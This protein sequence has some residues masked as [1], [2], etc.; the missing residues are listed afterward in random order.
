MEDRPDQ[1]VRDLCLH[2]LSLPPSERESFLNRNCGEGTALLSEVQSLLAYETAATDFL[3][4]PPLELA[5]RLL[6]QREMES[7]PLLDPELKT[8][9]SISHYEI[10]EKLGAGGM[11]LVY[12]ARDTELDR[13]VALKFLPDGGYED[14]HTLERFRREARAAAALNHPNVCTIHE[15]CRDGE[16]VFLVMEFLEGITLKEAIRGRSLGNEQILKLAIQVAE[17]LKAGHEAGIIHCDIKSAN[18]FLT[19][20]GAKIL[21]FGLAR[22]IEPGQT[23]D[24]DRL[25]RLPPQPSSRSTSG[26]SGTTRGAHGTVAYMSPEQVSGEPVDRRTDLFS[27]GVVLYEMTTGDLPFKGDSTAEIFDRILRHMPVPAT[28]L[29]P[30]FPA[31]LDGIID[32]ALTKDRMSRY[33]SAD[34]LLHDLVEFRNPTDRAAVV[35]TTTWPKWQTALLLLSTL[36]ILSAV[37]FFVYSRYRW[38]GLTNQDTIVLAE[39]ENK[40][41]DSIFDQTLQQAL[42]VQLEQSIF[43]NVL[44][45]EK[46]GEQLRF[47]A[48][49]ADTPVSREVAREICLRTGSQAVV[50]GSIS[51]LADD[52]V[53][54][55]N[56]VACQ[57][58]KSLASELTH[59]KNRDQVL[60]A[61]G[62]I[63]AKLRSKLGESLTSIQKYDAPVQDTT[64]A[65]LSALQAYT[66][67]M[68]ARR[69]AGAAAAIPFFKEAIDLDPEFASAHWGL[70]QSYWNDDRAELGDAELRKAFALRSRVSEKERLKIEATY[71]ENTTG[72][73]DKAIAVYELWRKIYPRDS[74]ALRGLGDLYLVLGEFDNARDQFVKEATIDPDDP[75]DYTALANAYL[76]L[77]E[78]DKANQAIEQ[79]QTRHLYEPYDEGILYYLAFERGDTIEMKRRLDAALKYPEIEDTIESVQADTE[80]YFGRLRRSREFTRRAADT[81]RRNGD[82]EDAT[83]YMVDEALREADFGNR[84][85]AKKA[86]TGLRLR[87]HKIVEVV[88]A[89][90]L[91]RTGSDKLATAMCDDLVR[92]FPLDLQVNRYW[93]PTVRAA[94]ELDRGNPAKAIELLQ[95]TSQY[96][97]AKTITVINAIPYPIYLR[98]SAFLALGLGADAAAEFQKILNHPGTVINYPLGALARLGLA[99]AYAEQAGIRFDTIPVLDRPLAI[100]NA[101]AAYETFFELWK[102]A[103][104]GIPL[105]RQ[106]RSEYTRLPPQNNQ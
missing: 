13:L 15:I 99:R 55:L 81:A 5:A 6:E 28:E 30:N 72:E 91:A 67:G 77:N 87:P 43:L 18:I 84:A 42:R 90:A 54:G 21:D 12:K 22:L 3:E 35:F 9:D 96:E 65:S 105:L 76:G 62:E 106:A 70:G 85:Q 61:L 33:Q 92:R 78:F 1:R 47:M 52:Y 59:V 41:G 86:L 26:T 14:T 103:D 4:T 79:A 48:R 93:V 53:I 2:A 50:A 63:S 60:G 34:E 88:G 64:T 101:R 17:G 45:G 57:D 89:L 73:E 24:G 74:L 11:G 51:R 29:N 94:M 104:N 68:K 58:G 39:F 100:A 38:H 95:A 56:A 20:H 27:F 46:E 44:S 25:D 75:Y 40:T 19:E 66:L 69:G 71:Y 37:A 83:S 31:G 10:I 82:E 102:S 8:G 36:S 16:R 7:Q 98:G 97:L 23:R 49:S 80:A 32:K